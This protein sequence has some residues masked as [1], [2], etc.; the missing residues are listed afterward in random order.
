MQPATTAYFRSICQS[1]LL[2]S[3]LS[4]ILS[5]A[6]NTPSADPQPNT[7]ELRDQIIYI[8]S[9]GWHTGIVI[10][11]SVMLAKLPTLKSQ[12]GHSP[13][14]EFGWGDRGFYQA[15]HITAGL[16][17]RALFWPTPSVV[18][19]VA[20]PENVNGYF[21]HSKIIKL[22]I[23][24]SSLEAL[25]RFIASSF[26]KDST[27]KPQSIG[28]GLY[29]SSQFYVGVGRF[30]L[31]NTCNRWTAQGLQR[32]GLDITPIFY[33]TASRVMQ[34]VQQYQQSPLFQCN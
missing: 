11:T 8:V 2:A 22:C 1:L 5:T 9:H 21:P 3:L 13:N 31:T 16:T 32:A 28:S 20:A 25:A 26:Y 30:Y 4:L 19:A 34:V 17:L 10:P 33:L 7:P 15:E 29:G 14:I 27:G 18:H 24:R 23:N 6:A 12:F